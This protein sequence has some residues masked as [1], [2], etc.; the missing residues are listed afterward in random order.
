MSAIVEHMFVPCMVFLISVRIYGG[1]VHGLHLA[2]LLGGVS[3]QAICAC[4]RLGGDEGKS[5]T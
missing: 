4:M 5:G 2:E 1:N 3:E